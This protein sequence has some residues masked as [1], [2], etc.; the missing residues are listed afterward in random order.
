MW[1]SRRSICPFVHSVS[2]LQD[3]YAAVGVV[4]P[5]GCCHPVRC[6][7]LSPQVAR[8]GR[9]RHSGRESAATL[10]TDRSPY[11]FSVPPDDPAGE[12]GA[13]RPGAKYSAGPGIGE[14]KAGEG[15]PLVGPPAAHAEESADE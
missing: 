14:V 3:S 5:Q 12:A 4:K 6:W 9:W 10:R 11:Q 1:G 8:K 15:G 2:H 13:L 7:S